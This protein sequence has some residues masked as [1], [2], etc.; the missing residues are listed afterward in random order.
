MSDIGLVQIIE[1]ALLAADKPLTVAQ[2]GDLFEEHER[3][4][5]TAIREALTEAQARCDERGLLLIGDPP[6]VGN[7]VLPGNNYHVYDIPLFWKNVQQDVIARVK[8]WSAAS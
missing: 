5:N 7:A 8:G 3:P 2:L 4:D 1:G 6:E